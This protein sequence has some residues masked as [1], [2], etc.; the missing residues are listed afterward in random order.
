MYS[1]IS[2]LEEWRAVWFPILAGG[3]LKE[4]VSALLGPD[5]EEYHEV[6]YEIRASDYILSNNCSGSKQRP[7]KGLT[8]SDNGLHGEI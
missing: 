2:L 1:R 8:M 7:L 4:L 5:D 3:I 6:K